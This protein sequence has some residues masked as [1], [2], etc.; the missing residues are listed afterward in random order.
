MIWRERARS[1]HPINVTMI[2]TND[3]APTW[4]QWASD[5]RSLWEVIS[6]SNCSHVGPTIGPL[7]TLKDR[8]G[9]A[10]AG[11]LLERCFRRPS[12]GLLT[13][14][15][16]ILF[17]R[18]KLT[19]LREESAESK[20]YNFL[21]QLTWLSRRFLFVLDSS[22]SAE[23]L[24]V[25]RKRIS[26]R[27]MGA[28]R[29]HPKMFWL[30][31]LE[32]GYYYW[33]DLS[34]LTI[35]DYIR[36]LEYIPLESD[37]RYID[38]RKLRSLM[39]EINNRYL[40][41]S[42][43]ASWE[44]LVGRQPLLDEKRNVLRFP[45]IFRVHHSL[46]DGVALLRLLLESIV[47]K[48]VPSR[49]K[50]L[51]NFKAMNLE[52]RIQQNAN[53]FLQQRSLI[54]KLYQRIP[55][56]RQIY[57]W[58]RQQLQLLWTIFTAPAFFHDVS[59]RAVDHNCIHA[60]EL[61]NQKVVSWIHE[62]EHS[63]THWVE[64]IKRTKQQLPGARFSDAFLTA[65]SSSLQKY[66]SRKTDQVPEDITVVLPTRVERESPQLKLHN[67]FSVALQTLPITSGIDL[68]DPNRMQNLMSRLND[69]KQHSDALR[70]SPDYMINYWI[71]NTVACLFPDNL[72]RK[73]LNSAH[74]TMAISNLPGPQQKPQINGRELK[75][76]SF[77]IP[78]IG[79]T[80]V[81][82]TL[83]TYGGKL[84]LGILADRAVIATEDDAHSILAETIAEIER[85]DVVLKGE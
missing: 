59:A 38:E 45:V 73:I 54:E 61:S 31:K 74:S 27:L 56:A 55:T 85:M 63:D 44:I 12:W 21:K 80:A 29:S 84:Q 50:R 2:S 16:M 33:S 17:I 78:N 70:S 51:S 15:L 5:Q 1:P 3:S 20:A 4:F 11:N 18:H 53:R 60:S 30:R 14:V 68:S 46:G 77:W 62:E 82:L 36:Y 43:T 71:M 28:I 37:E 32:L 40:L 9:G 22:T 39:S 8:P 35:E 83:L 75:N 58:K 26:S 24:L 72:L 49:W 19:R 69:V 52:Y 34:D 41:R 7:V 65:L 48:E 67:K 66:L 79:Q 25:L 64:V 57:T 81:G 10:V 47:D 6:R 23:M 76:L 42:H 13:G